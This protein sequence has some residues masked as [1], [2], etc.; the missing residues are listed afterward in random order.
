MLFIFLSLFAVE[1]CSAVMCYYSSSADTVRCDGSQTCNT[2]DYA[3]PLPSGTFLVGPQSGSHSGGWLNLYPVVSEI[4]VWDYYTNV[5][6]FGCRGGFGLH[7]GTQ[8]LGCITISDNS[9]WNSIFNAITATPVRNV[10]MAG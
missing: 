4:H 5:P 7:E 2:V 3:D 6:S 9:C 8:S 10:D 1:L